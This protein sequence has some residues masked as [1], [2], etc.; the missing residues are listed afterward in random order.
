MITSIWYASKYVAPSGSFLAR[1]RGYFLMREQLPVLGNQ[2]KMLFTFAC[3]F[4][5]FVDG[6]F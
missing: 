6:R 3:F 5:S 1:G 4:Y 2:E